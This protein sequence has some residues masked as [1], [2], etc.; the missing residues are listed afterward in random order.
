VSAA[1]QTCADPPDPTRIF[2]RK[3]FAHG[4]TFLRKRASLSVRQVARRT[5][6]PPGTLGDYYSGRYLPAVNQ[7]DVLPKILDACGVSDKNAVLEWKNAL[8]RVRDTRQAAGGS[9][10]YRGLEAFEPEDADWFFGR[11]RL[12]SMLVR[13]LAD[14]YRRG[15]PL[16]V[17]GVSGS[18]KSSLLRA[19][20]IPALR[21]GDPDL[22]GSQNWPWLLFN[23]GDHPLAELATQL[24]K[25]IRAKPAELE[26]ALRSDPRAAAGLARQACG[27]NDAGDTPSG[28]AAADPGARLVVV[29]DQFEEVFTSCPDEAERSAFIAALGAAAGSGSCGRPAGTARGGPSPSAALVV[30][31]L[32]A[33]FYPRALRRADL[34]PALQGHVVVEPMTK[35]ELREAI[36]KP[37]EKAGVD[38]EDGLVELL[39][40]D[41][42]P[43][44][45]AGDWQDDRK[46]CHDSP[47]HE[48]GALPLLS[49]ALHVT[50]RRLQRG[51]MT[52]AE[53]E[54]GGGIR[55][56]LEQT[57]TEAY[58]ELTTQQKERARQLFLRLV[59][60]ADDAADTRRRVSRAEILDSDG[61]AQSEDL[62]AVLKQFVDRRLI[63]E[64]RDHVEIAHDSLLSAWPRLRE[65]IN[66][67]RSMLVIIRRV[68]E[69]AH[70]WDA[71]GRDPGRLYRGNQLALA[72]QAGSA[73]P[74]ALPQ[75]AR[76]FL[77]AS[78]AARRR[79][80]YV[81]TAVIA[82]M[83][84]LFVFSTTAALM[85]YQAKGDRRDDISRALAREAAALRVKQPYR[86]LL[87][88]IEAY[89]IAPT[90]DARNSLLDSQRSYKMT[91]LGCGDQD[92]HMD[93]VVAVRWAER[94]GDGMGVLMTAGR[95]GKVN[96]W[97]TS[98]DG[99]H[100]AHEKFFHHGG[101]VLTAALSRD[102]TTVATA[103]QD[104]SIR[105]WDINSGRKV[106][107]AGDATQANAIDF[108]PGDADVVATAGKD[109]SVR[110]WSLASGNPIVSFK[111]DDN[112]LPV[113]AVVFSPDSRLLAT[114]HGNGTVKLWEAS[115]SA[116]PELLKT[117]ITH[118]APNPIR[119]LA[120]SPDRE[121]LAIGVD[122]DVLLCET[123]EDVLRKRDDLRCTTSAGERAGQ[124]RALLFAPGRGEKVLTGGDK[125]LVGADDASVRL[126]DTTTRALRSVYTGPT[127][128]VLDVAF[129]PDGQTVA[130]AGSDKTVGLWEVQAGPEGETGD[131]GSPRPTENPE[132]DDVIDWV[133]GYHPTPVLP[134]RPES[135]PAE[136]SR[137]IC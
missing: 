22:R 127:G 104:G 68:I 69:D 32:R 84:I 115:V 49:H 119:V 76:N 25:A 38:I 31:G 56:A 79:W 7:P 45:G 98:S 12:T 91:P 72:E 16:V 118:T 48:A 65:W 75:V 80:A 108:Y 27:A 15:G 87:L 11:Q 102:G 47:A 121:N 132:P 23:P 105:A 41:L 88:S 130:A 34:L 57:A 40:R 1:G 8:G 120:F 116:V 39:L 110:L 94:R 35:G 61:H 86:S 83:A 58:G 46:E 100:R 20:L 101:P 5:G 117:V 2:T 52:V 26:E 73:S 4:L 29:V 28:P 129:S 112:D 111:T 53:Y 131:G 24:A 124:V 95:D 74:M 17:I 63:T 3:H 81:R 71:K 125:L 78:V 126:L 96:V 82:V 50:W 109:G 114:A 133:C 113:H 93:A 106:F 90:N 66:A 99:F 77:K 54:A 6:I 89:R 135:I 44:P 55:G 136:F 30:L 107:D 13:E 37:A 51:R 128:N 62:A 19:G 21:R 70:A 97:L 33:D 137:D 60:I 43:E 122:A 9:T 67:D 36:V 85:A 92:C 14:R 10:P 134:Q 64:C 18:G 59:H 103:G 123:A 42:R